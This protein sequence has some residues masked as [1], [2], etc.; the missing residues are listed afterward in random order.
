MDHDAAIG[1]PAHAFEAAA[2]VLLD[3]ID[4][5][6]LVLDASG[7]V[8]LAN[9]AVEK[10]LD[11]PMEKM[12]GQSA[13]ELGFAPREACP[14]NAGGDVQVRSANGEI[15]LVAWSSHMIRGADGALQYVVA[16]GADVTETRA[17]EARLR[18]SERRFRELAENVNDLVAELDENGVFTYV[19]RRFEEVLGWPRESFLGRPVGHHMHLTDLALARAGLERLRSEFNSRRGLMRVRHKDGEYRSLETV[20]T[21]FTG[22]DGKLRMAVVAR[23][24][25]KRMAAEDELRRVDRLVTLGTFAAG[26]SHEINN[27]VAA[28]L[29]AA[30]VALE[31]PRAKGQD[32]PAMATLENIAA[33]ARRCGAIVRAML[34][35]ASHGRSERRVHETNDLVGRALS[36]VEP[37]A[38]EHG[39]QLRLRCTPGPLPILANDVEIEQVVVNLV[40]NAVE[41]GSANVVVDVETRRLADRVAITVTDNG[42][43]IPADARELVFEPFF[44]SKRSS[45]GTGLGLAIARRIVGDHGGEIHIEDPETRGSRFAVE[46]PFASSTRTG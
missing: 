12:L 18:E 36:L 19:N 40:R 39:A 13:F 24:I 17:T 45:G 37:Y 32:A 35:F 3:A 2:H 11:L 14:D 33:H 46:L 26:V 27:P 5:L 22:P 7:R 25:T 28:I 23:D 9:R 1:G 29:L 15:R 31:R 30:E 20:V 16:T 6:V 34:D 41:S 8:V 44:S 4:T 42:E 21:S 38:N 43:G 10:I